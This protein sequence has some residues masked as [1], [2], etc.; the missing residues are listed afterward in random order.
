MDKKHKSAISKSPSIKNKNTSWGDV[1]DWYDNHLSADDDNYHTKVIFPNLIRIL[2]DIKGKNCIDLACG[3]GIFTEMLA[4]ESASSFGIDISKEL[5]GIA[6]NRLAVNKIKN[7]E[8]FVSPSDDLFMVKDNSKDFVVCVLALQ[9]IEKLDETIKEI[10][11]VLKKSGSFIFVINHPTFRNPKKTS[12]GYDE[13]ENI[14]YR[15]VDEYM[16]ESSVKI[17]M[18]PGNKT[19]KKFTVS[20]HRPLQVY[21]KFLSKNGFAITRMEEWISHKESQ[22]GPKQIAENKS[23]KEIPLFMCIEA[24]KLN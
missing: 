16:S 10:S 17:D 9:N 11:R 14:Q 3:Q 24:K 20:F 4:K 23:R 13:S 6:K 7:I 5:I 18:T 1:A 22:K 12:W 8:Y 2:G 19:N 15:R 21:A